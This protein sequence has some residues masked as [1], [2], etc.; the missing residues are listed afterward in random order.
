MDVYGADISLGGITTFADNVAN[1]DGGAVHVS[2]SSLTVSRDTTTFSNN[3]ATTGGGGALGIYG[4][5]SD[6]SAIV[7]MYG[8]TFFTGNIASANVGAIYSASNP[9][10]Q[11]FQDATFH[12]NSATWGGAVATFGTGNGNELEELPTYSGDANSLAKQ[13]EKVGERWKLR[14]DG[15]ALLTCISRAMPQVCGARQQ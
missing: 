6:N 15:S 3:S 11:F 10:G 13:S 9:T 12:S 5:L 14:L 8:E 7:N 4:F 2:A 1:L